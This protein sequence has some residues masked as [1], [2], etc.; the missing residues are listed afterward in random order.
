[1]PTAAEEAI[2][3]IMESSEIFAS[4]LQEKV[5]NIVAMGFDPDEVKEFALGH[6]DSPEDYII[7]ILQ[8]EWVC[9]IMFHHCFIYVMQ[10]LI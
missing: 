4:E 10:S 2:K 8:T 6:W 9:S 3:S 5:S 1:L 7:R